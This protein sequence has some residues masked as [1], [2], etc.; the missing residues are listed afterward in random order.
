MKNQTKE[1]VQVVLNGFQGYDG[2]FYEPCHSEKIELVVDWNKVQCPY[3][4]VWVECNKSEKYPYLAPHGKCFC[5]SKNDKTLQT[6]SDGVAG[7]WYE[8]HY[9][10]Y[11]EF[12]LISRT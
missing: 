1:E 9:D 6:V 12:F 11:Y 10:G 7:S 8:Q 5:E 2:G 3:C 4:G